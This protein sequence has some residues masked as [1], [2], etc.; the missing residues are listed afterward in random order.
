[1]SHLRTSR[2]AQG[3]LDDDPFFSLPP[4]PIST[5]RRTGTAA[6]TNVAVGNSDAGDGDFD[7]DFIPRFPT[8]ASNTFPI[9]A[10]NQH[11]TD[12]PEVAD[13]ETP[14]D[15]SASLQPSCVQDDGK[16]TSSLEGYAGREKPETRYLEDEC[17]SEEPVS[18]RLCDM[19]VLRES[20]GE[21]A[22]VTCEILACCTCCE[23]CL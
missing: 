17:Y 6:R 23:N 21:E 14:H 11:V 10:C 7:A 2:P 16:D 15:Q 5:L 22:E 4:R 18:M 9:E 12:I 8:P 13:P 20:A 19:E 3:V 1:M